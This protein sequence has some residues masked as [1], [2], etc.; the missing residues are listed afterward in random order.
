MKNGLKRQAVLLRAIASKNQ[1][2]D[3]L[4]FCKNLKW[5]SKS[6]KNGFAYNENRDFLNHHP[7][8]SRHAPEYR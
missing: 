7:A 1:I 4:C 2:R 6:R 5:I 3:K 8:N